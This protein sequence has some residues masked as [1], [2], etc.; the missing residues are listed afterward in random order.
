MVE[1]T[2]YTGPVPASGSFLPTLLDEQPPDSPV[3]T[4]RTASGPSVLAPAV[5]IMPCRRMLEHLA[6]ERS[7]DGGGPPWA[8]AWLGSPSWIVMRPRSIWKSRALDAKSRWP[9]GTGASG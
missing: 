4:A 2:A 3:I 6:S 7:D 1:W 9:L 5:I 8:L